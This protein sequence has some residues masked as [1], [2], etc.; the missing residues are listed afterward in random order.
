MALKSSIAHHIVK[1]IDK[2]DKEKP[3]DQISEQMECIDNTQQ[4]IKELCDLM[5]KCE[6]IQR[7][8]NKYTNQLIDQLQ[9]LL[10]L[11]V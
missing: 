11:C 3:K 6:A 8:Q 2:M 9:S 10:Y 7:K 5:P 1:T 4:T